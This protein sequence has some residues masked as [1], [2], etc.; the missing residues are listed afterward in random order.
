MRAPVLSW[1][2]AVDPR[3]QNYYLANLIGLGGALIGVSVVYAAGVHSPMV[4]ATMVVMAVALTIVLAGI[5]LTRT[6][7][8]AA[9]V[10]AMS[11]STMV[12]GLGATW[13]SPFLA[14]LAVT[15]QLVPLTAALAHVGRRVIRSV[16][17]VTLVVG[18]L[19]VAIAELRRPDAEGIH[20]MAAAISSAAAL[21]FIIVVLAMAIQDNYRRLAEQRDALRESRAQIVSVADA[22][23]RGL[24]RDLHDGA[25]QRLVLMSVELGRMRS[26]LAEGNTAEA[27][28]VAA[29]VV[30]HHHEALSE[31]RDLAQGIY[32]PLLAERGLRPALRAAAR[33]CVVPCTV[34]ADD[35]PRYDEAVEAA[36]YFCILEALQNVVKHSGAGE[37][38]VELTAGPRLVF[39]VTDDG[40]GFDPRE[41]PASGGLLGMQARIAA[42]GGRLEVSSAP[43]EGTTVRGLLSAAAR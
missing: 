7:G 3:L 41:H 8:P 1:G 26:L 2:E 14:P 19:T 22:T 27:D 10:A 17:A 9:A 40:A 4:L 39:E 42:A 34:D 32:P 21:P 6:W 30:R 29:A 16:L 38:R 25:Q 31:L 37:V 5:P 20:P 24:E 36:V 12:F 23:R 28:E 15:A 13:S 11:A 35:L 33:R 18:P 43:G